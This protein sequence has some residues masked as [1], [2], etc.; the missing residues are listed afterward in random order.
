[1]I[2]N[3]VLSLQVGRLAHPWNDSL[4]S[5]HIL[6]CSGVWRNENKKLS[7]MYKVLNLSFQFFLKNNCSHAHI[8]CIIPNYCLTETPLKTIVHISSHLIHCN[9]IIQDKIFFI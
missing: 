2:S 5:D 8:D 7:Y 6:S 1:M 9:I 4:I 3:I